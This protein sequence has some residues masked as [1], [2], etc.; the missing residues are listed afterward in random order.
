MTLRF[1]YGHYHDF[2]ALAHQMAEAQ[3]DDHFPTT[4]LT[5]PDISHKRIWAQIP[6]WS[7]IELT[8]WT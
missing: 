5:D 3:D 8:T 4:R 7:S 1:S 2:E 6:A